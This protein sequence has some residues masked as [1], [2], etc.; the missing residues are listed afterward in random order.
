MSPPHPR[1]RRSAAS[2]GVL[3]VLVLLLGPNLSACS[4]GDATGDGAAASA[5]S[6]PGAT[7]SAPGQAVTTTQP[8]TA[9][10]AGCGTEPPVTATDDPAGDVER[11]FD[12]EAGPRSYRLAVPADYDRDVPAPVILNLHGAGSNAVQQ[13]V[14]SGLPHRGAERG[15]LVVTPDAVGGMWE[16]APEGADDVFLTALLDRID[17]D[18]CVDPDRVHAAGI[19]LGAWKAS[20]TACAHPDRFASIALVAE[21]VAPAGC[22]L[23][24]V[25]FH[26]TADTVVPFGEGADEGVVVTGPNTGLPGV[27]VNMPAWAAGAGCAAEKDVE[28]IEPD[29]ERWI[30]RDCP[31]GRGVE[32]Y[33][34]EGAG[35]VWPGSPVRLPGANDT[36]DATAIALDWFEAH[37]RVS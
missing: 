37:P 32:L 24:V 4:A 19:S 20:V 15:F 21:E 36:V 23:P 11:T 27:E 31:A 26:G 22:A 18:F 14:Y 5:P 16:L 29:V 25:A 13:S 17:T 33:A 9:G 8:S 6:A 34:I 1:R 35:H 30:Y 3:A 10:T 12:G 7:A 2:S 28:R